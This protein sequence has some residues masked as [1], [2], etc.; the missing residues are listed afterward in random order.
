[1]IRSIYILYRS[2]SL[3]LNSVIS[4]SPGFNISYQALPLSVV[5]P[6]DPLTVE[7]PH[8]IDGYLKGVNLQG[9]KH[10]TKCTWR[11]VAPSSDMVVKVKRIDTQGK[12]K[13]TLKW[14]CLVEGF[15]TLA[16]AGVLNLPDKQVDPGCWLRSGFEFPRRQLVVSLF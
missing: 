4:L 5:C 16:S 15:D 13:Y 8:G 12:K 2:T 10:T 7:V 11:L 3:S 6:H 9:G 14:A 1:M